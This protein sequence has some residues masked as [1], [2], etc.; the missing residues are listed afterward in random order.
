MMFTIDALQPDRD[1]AGLICEWHTWV[2][3]ND[4]DNEATHLIRDPQQTD[5]EDPLGFHAGH[6]CTSHAALGFLLMACGPRSL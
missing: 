6:L 1:G 3:G 5:P 2:G 4:C